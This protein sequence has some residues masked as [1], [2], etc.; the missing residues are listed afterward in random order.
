MT[1]SERAE[2]R[3]QAPAP[4]ASRPPPAAAAA[5]PRASTPAS[6]RA[7][8]S[9]PSR[10]G[11]PATCRRCRRG[12]ARRRRARPRRRRSGRRCTPQQLRAARRPGYQDGYRDGLVALEGF[13]Q[14][15]AQPDDDA[16]RRAVRSI[17]EQLDALQQ[18][19]AQALARDGDCAGAPGACAASSPLRPELVAAVAQ[20]GARRPAAERAPHH[21]ARPPDDQPWSPKAR[22]KCSRR[23]ARASSPMPPCSAAVA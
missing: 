22:P 15:F 11:S 13:K 2:R 4:A 21:A 7:R 3:C 14:S 6:S 9:A 5:R 12:A 10:P 20:R 19:M 18:E 17:G 16:G 8:S 1:S 23:A